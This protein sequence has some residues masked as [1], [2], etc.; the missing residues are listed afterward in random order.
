MVLL[1]SALTGVHGRARR[2]NTAARIDANMTT[3][4]KSMSDRRPQTDG[5]L[6]ID[7]DV[8]AESAL[9]GAQAVLQNAINAAEISRAELARQMGCSLPFVTRMLTGDHNMTVRTFARGLIA[10]GVEPV[11]QYRPTWKWVEGPP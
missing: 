9:A 8:L 3:R 5:W 2:Y 10:C 11:F 6:P 1:K 4:R 7:R